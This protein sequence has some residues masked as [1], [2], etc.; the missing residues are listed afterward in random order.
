MEAY[1]TLKRQ[2]LQQQGTAAHSGKLIAALCANQNQ[3]QNQLYCQVGFHIQGICCGRLVHIIN[4]A[5][6][7]YE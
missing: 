2:Q 6:G 7:Q 4:I 3:N 1:C 5:Q